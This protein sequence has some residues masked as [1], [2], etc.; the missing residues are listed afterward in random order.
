MPDRLRF[1]EP[2]SDSQR[3]QAGLPSAV[4]DPGDHVVV[5]WHADQLVLLVLTTKTVTDAKYINNRSII[6]FPATRCTVLEL[7][8]T[9]CYGGSPTIR[10]L[11]IFNAQ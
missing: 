2:A 5:K 10:E 4:V 8:I 3:W 6:A 1:R 9:A 7:K 11:G